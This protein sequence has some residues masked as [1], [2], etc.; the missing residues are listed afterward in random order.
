MRG[1]LA[2]DLE[3]DMVM[4]ICGIIGNFGNAETERINDNESIG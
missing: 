2:G 1:L 4:D 3:D